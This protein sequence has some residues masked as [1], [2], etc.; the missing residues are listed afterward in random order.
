MLHATAHGHDTTHRGREIVEN[1]RKTA[2]AIADLVYPNIKLQTG[3]TCA[4]C[5]IKYRT[6][7]I[8]YFQLNEIAS[9]TTINTLGRL[10][11]YRHHVNE[12]N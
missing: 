8:N 11:K 6:V 9:N 3:I 12:T 1:A 4:I 7:Y 5:H 2:P 10:M